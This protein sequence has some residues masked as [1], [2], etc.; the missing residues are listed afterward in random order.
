MM[1]QQQR[2]KP[3]DTRRD[4]SKE[5]KENQRKESGNRG[6][7]DTPSR[8]FIRREEPS[9]LYQKGLHS[10]VRNHEPVTTAHAHGISHKR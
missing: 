2:K 7:A 4:N 1:E 8:C 9:P 10:A 6:K 3:K 5:G